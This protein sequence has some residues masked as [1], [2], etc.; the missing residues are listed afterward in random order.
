MGGVCG[1]LVVAVFMASY[2]FA[3]E[4]RKGNEN[5]QSEYTD[6]YRVYIFDLSWVRRCWH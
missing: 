5:T 2:Y 4:K 1:A 6:E 3:V